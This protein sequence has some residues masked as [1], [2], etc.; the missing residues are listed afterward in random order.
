MH[1]TLVEQFQ[2]CVELAVAASTHPRGARFTDA[3]RGEL[4]AMLA[5]AR[6]HDPALAVELEA[7]LGR[8]GLPAHDDR[9]EGPRRRSSE[10]P[11]SGK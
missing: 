1:R 8:Y 9:Q 10:R 2:E 4:R 11:S 5:A 7:A 6:R 3:L